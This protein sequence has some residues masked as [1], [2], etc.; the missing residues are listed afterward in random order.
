[1]SDILSTSGDGLPDDTPDAALSDQFAV[2][3]DEK[4]TE[5]REAI[6]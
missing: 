5:I 6:V 4:I 3:F 2:F 1:M